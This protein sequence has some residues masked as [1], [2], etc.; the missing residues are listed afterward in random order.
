MNKNTSIMKSFNNMINLNM[1]LHNNLYIENQEQ[2]F[3]LANHIIT[4]TNLENENKKLKGNTINL[5]DENKKLKGNIQNLENENTTLKYNIQQ[6]CKSS[7]ELKDTS[8]YVFKQL[9]EEKAKNEKNKKEYEKSINGI[10]EK[11]KTVNLEINEKIKI[12]DNELKRINTFDTDKMKKDI[13]SL[14]NTL[15]KLKNEIK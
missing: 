14:Q 13:I 1:I 5:E 3:K 12:I 9:E 6:K 8:A 7:S 4:I 2:K 10:L 15:D 11:I